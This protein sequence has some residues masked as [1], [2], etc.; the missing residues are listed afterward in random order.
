MNRRPAAG[1]CIVDEHVDAIGGVAQFEKR[2]RDCVLVGDVDGDDNRRGASVANRLRRFV[3]LRTRPRCNRDRAPRL[4]G[5]NYIKRF[6]GKYP[7]VG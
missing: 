2:R 5:R 6:Y 1:S 7:L 3:Q 4:R